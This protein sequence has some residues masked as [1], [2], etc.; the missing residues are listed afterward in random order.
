MPR[1][2]IT[3]DGVLYHLREGTQIQRSTLR[4][5][6]D[7]APVSGQPSEQNYLP[8]SLTTQEAPLGIGS[9]LGDDPDRIWDEENVWTIWPDYISLG[10]LEQT[11]TFT[12]GPTTFKVTQGTPFLVG[13]GTVWMCG[14]ASGGTVEPLWYWVGSSETWTSATIGADSSGSVTAIVGGVQIGATMYVAGPTPP[15]I[16]LS[17]DKTTWTQLTTSGSDTL[18]GAADRLKFL[19]TIDGE[20]Y[21]AGYV[22]ASGATTVQKRNATPGSG[23]TWTSIATIPEATGPPRGMAN[24]PGPDGDDDFI[25]TTP[26]ALYHIDVSA[27]AARKLVDF[28]HTQSSFTGTL[29]V[30][31]DGRV[32]FTDGQNI[33]AMRW[34]DGSGAFETE[35]DIG[36][37]T[38]HHP[39]SGRWRWTAP[40]HGGAGCCGRPRPRIL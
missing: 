9:R 37:F 40:C 26:T 38:G 33:H 10:P 39:W 13:L 30:G 36:P 34:L 2:S 29:M 18:A 6:P 8:H 27:T 35:D 14:A 16:R 32:Y 17:T 22:N 24:Y 25:V 7:A 5:F 21:S 1:L 3:L 12:G 4:G 20:L 19:L 31:P 28:R 11:P 23:L 15:F